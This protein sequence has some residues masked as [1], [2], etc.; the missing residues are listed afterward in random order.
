M[1][2][3]ILMIIKILMITPSG[4][5]GFLLLFIIVEFGILKPEKLS[6]RPLVGLYTVF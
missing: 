2:I 4:S 3:V 5:L 6:A 1:V